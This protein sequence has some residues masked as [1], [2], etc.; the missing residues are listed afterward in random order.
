MEQDIILTLQQL[1]K[2]LLP[3][4]RH[5]LKLFC[6][7][8]IVLSTASMYAQNL[9]GK[10]YTTSDGLI[11]DRVTC[12]VQDEKG[13]MW[14]GTYFGISRY[15]GYSF[16]TIPLPAVQQNKY[17]A[18]LAAAHGNVYAG[19]WF[20]GGLLEYSNGNVRAYALPAGNNFKGNDVTALGVHP[21]EGMLVAGAG[22][23]VFHFA[24]GKFKFLFALDSNFTHVGIGCLSIDQQGN[25]WAGTVKGLVVYTNNHRLIRL[26]EKNIIYLREGS[27]GMMVVSGLGLEYQVEQFNATADSFILSKTIWKSNTALPI[28]QNSFHQDK[29]WI[30]DT[31]NRLIS[32]TEDGKATVSSTE[33]IS[34][35]DIHFLYADRENN[36]WIATHTGVVKMSNL[37]ALSYAFPQKAFGS[38]DISG[39]DSLLW[40]TNSQSLF[41]LQHQRLQQVPE[42]RPPKNRDLFGRVFCDGKYLWTSGWKGGLWRL[43]IEKD[44]IISSQYFKEFE[45]TE[46]KVHQL[47]ADP[48]GNVWIAGEN[49]IFYFRDGK[50]VNH[51][52]PMLAN[53]R[54]MFVV[55]LALDSVHTTLWI[56]ENGEGIYKIH[57]SISPA[58]I[59]YT[60]L[61]NINAKDGLDD[62]NIRSLLLDSK[63][64]LWAGT[65]FGGIYHISRAAGKVKV[66]NVSRQAPLNC[67]RVTDIKEDQEN[68]IWFATCNGVYR[69]SS[70]PDQWQ[71]Y[72][73]ANGLMDAEVFAHTIS[74]GS[75]RV[76]A[77]SPSGITAVSYGVQANLPPPIANITRI[78]VLG[79]NDTAALFNKG[80]FSYAADESSIGFQ[81]AGASYTDEKKVTY[82]YM[83]QGYDRQWSSPTQANTVNYV[84]LPPGDYVFKVLASSG[85]E[86]WSASPAT[87]SFTITQ[88]FY[89]RPWFLFALLCLLFTA[90]YFFRMYRLN[91]RLKVERIR[92]RISSDLHDD[93]GSTLSSISI[94]SEGAIQE[95]NPVATRQMVR[96]ISE[97]AQFLLDKMDDIIWCV[98]P[99]NDS[100]RELLLRIKKFSS[101]LFEAKGIDYDIVIDEGISDISLPMNYRQHIYLILKEAIN[102]LVKYSDASYASIN[103][104]QK[105]PH[106][107]ITVT[108][109]GKGFDIHAVEDGNGLRNMKKRAQDMNAQLEINTN[110]KGTRIFLATNI[111]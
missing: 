28:M 52:Q 99:R 29:I 41:T 103:I 60:M 61:E 64:T 10:K 6:S 16:T 21:V 82:K 55:T 20:D 7:C 89:K 17:V 108:D 92:S 36:L 32:I 19:L 24:N 48:T 31:T 53:G 43:Q 5:L 30:A 14:F 81:F 78:T 65:R 33:G 45:N 62:G 40:I 66:Q 47:V 9:P 101:S 58:G 88:P 8:C 109:N 2:G 12:A 49:G 84:S 90:F 42:F 86:Q 59:T 96:E 54:L 3:S 76:W 67:S 13:F 72:N 63:N 34:K 69:Y 25:I 106:I 4:V 73:T 110:A 77:V 87:F 15:D 100:F 94:I 46:I 102:N 91:E 27:N 85:N 11:A 111:K 51:F 23:A 68:N 50:I 70:Q 107:E 80:N 26:S 1:S 75:K 98:N 39:N 74:S 105:G 57:Y 37:P 44:K 97:N 83:L 35:N 18:T 95:K 71:W 79:K 93:I 22:N 38:A 56:G 104:S